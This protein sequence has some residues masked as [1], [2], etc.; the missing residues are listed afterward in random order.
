MK[1]LKDGIFTSQLKYTKELWEKYDHARNRE[2]KTLINSNIK[3]NH[4][5]N[6]P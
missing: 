6:S 4:Y 5:R 2:N 1:K 3:M